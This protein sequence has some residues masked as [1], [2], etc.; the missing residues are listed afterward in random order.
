VRIL[1]V[2]HDFLPRHR[3]GSE[4]YAFE[5]CRQLAA[6]GHEVHVLCAEYDPNRRHGT[7]VWRWYEDLPITE[8]VNNWAFATFAE[9]YSSTTINGQ[10]EHVLRAVRPDLLHIHNLLNLSFDLPRIARS[11]GIPSVATLHEFVLLCPS[12]GQ[13]VHL[14][15]EHV[16]LEIDPERCA[17]CFAQSHFFSQMVFGRLALSG[18]KGRALGGFASWLRRR[19][20]RVADRAGRVATSHAPALEVQADEI[21]ARLDAAQLV[22]ESIDLFVAPSPALGA[23]FRRFGMPEEKLRVSDYGFAPLEWALRAPRGRALRIGFVGTLVWHK[24]AHVIIDAL[25]R[26]PTEGWEMHFFGSLDTFPDYVAGL[27]EAAEGLPITFEGGFDRERVAEIYASMDVLVVSSLWPENSP[28]VIHEAFMA[29]VPV[30]GAR[31]GGTADLIEDD[32]C[33]LLY[34]AFSPES[35][36]QALR[37]LLDEPDLLDRL[38]EA[39]PPV[40]TLEQD[41]EEWEAV[42]A[43]VLGD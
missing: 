40:K 23:D 10:L 42:Y 31:M 20:P 1:H 19:F 36:A 3:A 35:L 25:R 2:I 34:D 37:R 24:G 15:E 9:S 21:R 29:G 13:R 38:A 27:R 18:G 8:L 32:R 6:R 11:H 12:G 26:L 16:C 22:Y 33:G 7:L 30:V 5:L 14:A 43:E 17:R 41:A 4:I 28:L 39:V